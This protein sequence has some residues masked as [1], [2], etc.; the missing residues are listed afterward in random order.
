MF[1]TAVVG[2]SLVP[3]NVCVS[4]LSDVVVDLY[5]YPGAAID[6]L[7][8]KHDQRDFWTK[9][10]D[11]VILCIGGNDLARD[12]VDQVF[13]K[14]CTL[15]RKVIAITKILT[16]CTVQY[17]LYPLGNQFGVDLEA[18]RCK[19]IKINRKIQRFMNCIKSRYLDMGKTGFT[20]NKV[21]DGVHFNTDGSVKFHN[22]IVSV[23][24]AVYHSRQ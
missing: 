14:L 5:H 23:I 15:A 19:V 8:N 11:L 10:Y 21:T 6:S 18:F 9:N 16:N 22:N 13:N 2:H 17:R 24:K 20:L 12:D 7:T 3:Q 1:C 4:D